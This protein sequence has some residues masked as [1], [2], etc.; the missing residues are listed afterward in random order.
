MGLSFR[1]C[2]N[3]I[4]CLDLS[5]SQVSVSFPFVGLQHTYGPMVILAILPVCFLC[6]YVVWLNGILLYR[7]FMD[8]KLK[9]VSYV[10]SVTVLPFGSSNLAGEW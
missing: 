2:L 10:V 4:H 7:I 1:H 3:F 9:Y 5:K 6:L 8:F